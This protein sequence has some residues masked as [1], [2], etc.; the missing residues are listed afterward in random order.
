MRKM[1]NFFK[2]DSNVRLLVVF[3]VFSIAGS[4]SIVVA[5]IIFNNLLKLED[6]DFMY[7]CLRIIIIVPIYQVLLV[8]TGT[9]CGEFRYFWEIEKRILRRLGLKL[10]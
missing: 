4:L 7:W 10:K 3:A 6:H 5:N 9:I 8:A 2:V 1:R